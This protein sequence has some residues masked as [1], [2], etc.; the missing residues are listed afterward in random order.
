MAVPNKQLESKLPGWRYGRD[1][2]PFLYPDLRYGSRLVAK[3]INYVMRD[4]KKSLARRIVYGA[5][6]LIQERTGQDPLEV[7]Y[8]A[9]QNCMPKLETRSRRVGGAAY[10]VPYEVPEDR[11]KTL[12]LRWIVNAARERSERTMIERLAA[13][14]LDAAQGQGRAYEKKLE[15][16]RMAEA[17]RAFAHYRW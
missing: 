2:P 15:S 7:F 17:N 13:E 9:V 6:D 11:Q 4:G 3:L 14:I 10:Q 5:F 8:K 16:H 1:K 12:A